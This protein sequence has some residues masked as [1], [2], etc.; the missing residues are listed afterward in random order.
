M[1]TFFLDS[2]FFNYVVLPLL[3]MLARIIDV[4]IGTVRI[5]MLSK[6]K[7][8]LPPVLGFIEVLIWIV[9]ITKIMQ[10]LDN[11]VTY[12]AYAGGFAIG[13][14]IGIILEEKMALG[15][16]IVR[17]ITSKPADELICRLHAANYGTTSVEAKGSKQDVNVIY[18]IIQRTELKKVVEIIKKYNP[19]AFYSV[20]DVK[21]VSEGGLPSQLARLGKTPDGL[22]Y[23][24][25]RKGK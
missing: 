2:S 22:R 16:M 19:K 9:A 20:E 14:Y 7:R 10:N 17:V 12:I 5:I 18:T 23:R 6:S 11:Y 1:E 13:N 4:S 15:V 3:I 8:F 25:W 24:R 21:F